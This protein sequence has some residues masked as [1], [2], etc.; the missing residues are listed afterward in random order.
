[1]HQHN[2]LKG[3]ATNSSGS[4]SNT[5][6]NDFELPDAQAKKRY[7]TLDLYAAPGAAEGRRILRHPPAWRSIYHIKGIMF[8][9]YDVRD[10]NCNTTTYGAYVTYTNLTTSLTEHM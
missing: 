1:M 4:R 6:K 7:T 9:L 8:P 10:M 2:S 3:N 5:N